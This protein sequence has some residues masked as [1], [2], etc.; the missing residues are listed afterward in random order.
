MIGEN[1]SFHCHIGL[2]SLSFHFVSFT[3]LQH[4]RSDT[5]MMV[6]RVTNAEGLL[7]STIGSLK[8]EKEKRKRL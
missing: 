1:L 8:K 2:V 5:V 6:Y 7:I 3:I 4:R